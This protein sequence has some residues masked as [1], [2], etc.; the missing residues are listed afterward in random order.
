LTTKELKTYVDAHTR[1]LSDPQQREG[2]LRYLLGRRLVREKRYD[3]A[4]AYLPPP[5]DGILRIYVKALKDGANEKLP[6]VDRARAWFTAGW[7]ARHDGEDL[8]G[9]E[10]RPV[11]GVV[12]ERRAGGVSW[13]RLE[14]GQEKVA[15][16]PLTLKATPEEVRRLNIY[17][18]TPDERHDFRFIAG[19]LAMKAAHLLPP[20]TEEF[21]DV[22]NTAGRWVKDRDE[23]TGDR[24]YQILEARA[25]KTEIGQAAIARHW[26][27]DRLGPWCEQ[28]QAA[29]EKMHHELEP[30]R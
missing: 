11:P 14:N 7:L 22:V 21:A 6:K 17:K 9:S 26:F 24:Y 30:G 1:G 23:K 19:A 20:Q 2:N 25:S 3:E 29:Y 15:F 16:E 28:Q 10:G 8:M 12:K 13:T 4:A 27:V 18:I 5:Y